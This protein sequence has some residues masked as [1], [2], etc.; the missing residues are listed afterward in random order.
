MHLE[1]AE[2]EIKGI[3]NLIG[4][5]HTIH[6][7][8]TPEN[9]SLFEKLNNTLVNALK[10]RKVLKKSKYDILF[11]NTAFDLNAIVRDS[12]TLLIIRHWSA[13]V[14][15]KFHGSDINFLGRLNW[16][17]KKLVSFIFQ[18]ADGIGV[19]SKDELNAFIKEG[20]SGKKIFIV[21]NPVNSDLYNKDSNFKERLGISYETVV[22]I[23]CGRFIPQKGLID[24]LS[25]FLKI[26]EEKKLVHLICIGDGPEM[27][28]AKSFVANHNLIGKVLFTGF[29]PESEI[30]VYY[31]N[32]DALVFPTYHQEGF[33][34]VV[35]Q[36]LAAG[37]PIITTR[38]RAAADYLTEP[39]HVLWVEPKDPENI[40]KAMKKLL[41]DKDT[42]ELM[43]LNNK[44]LS[45]QFT[46]EN[47][48]N[49]Y[50]NIFEEL[51]EK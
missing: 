43:S 48:A 35:F 4:E 44:K 33:P 50:K 18:N 47:N 3:R 23:F 15:L 38:I 51:L 26:Q 16:W 19:L 2:L 34:M 37:L 13:K 32:A 36:S 40:A 22:F 29:I 8:P 1:L 28:K 6:Y 20:Y 46:T 45:N 25:A 17:Q 5:C 41:R 27:V 49:D 42:R 9:N 30:I 24:V 12:I 7:G 11:L 21:K 39:D 10:I 31:S 14:F